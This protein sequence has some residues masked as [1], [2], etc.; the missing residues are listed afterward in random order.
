M[1]SSSID[2]V[3]VAIRVRPFIQSETDR[4][5]IQI[6]QKTPHEPQLEIAQVGQSVTSK[7]IY[8]YNNVFMPEDT[9]DYVYQEYVAKEIEKVFEG[10]NLTILAYGQ[11]LTKRN[12][13]INSFI[14]FSPLFPQSNR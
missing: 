6:V 7:D 12:P 11:V 13:Q 4:G 14:V 8:T 3:R 5:C 10:Y 1:S 2:S 9:Q